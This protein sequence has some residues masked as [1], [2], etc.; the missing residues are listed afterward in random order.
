MFCEHRP[1]GGWCSPCRRHV[2]RTSHRSARHPPPRRRSP[3]ST[4]RSPQVCPGLSHS[5]YPTIHHQAEYQ[6]LGIQITILKMGCQGYQWSPKS[7]RPK[8]F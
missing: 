5:A 2:C 1:S 4:A 8:M 6:L 3:V 7:V